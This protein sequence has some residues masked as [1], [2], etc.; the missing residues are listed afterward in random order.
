MTIIKTKTQ[1]RLIIETREDFGDALA[2]IEKS[3]TI[4]DP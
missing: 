3:T 1:L 2:K 4:T